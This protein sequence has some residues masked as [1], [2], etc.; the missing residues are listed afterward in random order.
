MKIGFIGAGKVGVSLGKYLAE[1][2]QTLSGY[3]SKNGT[4]TKEAATFT[5]SAVYTRMA[6]F[7]AET[8]LIFVTTSD[9]QIKNVWRILKKYPLEG[10]LIVHTSGVLASDVFEG[11]RALG[12][13][14]YSLHPFM[15]INSKKEGYKRL[16]VSTYTLEGDAEKIEVVRGII[17]KR[18]KVNII[19]GKNKALYHASAVFASNFTVALAHISDSM[20]KTV[21]IDDPDTILNIM[22]NTIVNLKTSGIIKAL[23]GPVERG[24][25]ETIKRHIDHLSENN[26]NIYKA[27]SKELVEI[28]TLKNENKD[29]TKAKQMLD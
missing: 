8:D 26:L 24:D 19:D 6:D 12:A 7:V 10:K 9:D 28:A 23:T 27:M 2:G 29:Y 20:L 17:P 21:G 4:S 18:N 16:S 15:A 22:E 3:I 25:T 5:N 14:G 1:N 11:I 13:Y